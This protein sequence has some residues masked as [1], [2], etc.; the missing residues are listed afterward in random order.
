MVSSIG[1]I[2][3]VD[4]EVEL[5]NILVAALTSHG[6]AAAGV[7]SAEEALATFTGTVRGIDRKFSDLILRKRNRSISMFPGRPSITT[8]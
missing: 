5:K 2:L 3:V 6:Y 1:K 4:D 7:N 8:V